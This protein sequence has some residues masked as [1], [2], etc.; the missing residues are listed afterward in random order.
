[1]PVN[2]E[3]GTQILRFMS[4]LYGELSDAISKVK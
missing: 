4:N 3:S 2:S 1:M